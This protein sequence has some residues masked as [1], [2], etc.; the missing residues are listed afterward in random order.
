MRLAI[1]ILLATLVVTQCLHGSDEIPGWPVYNEGRVFQGGLDYVVVHG[2]VASYCMRANSNWTVQL[3]GVVAQHIKA[4]N[5]RGKRIRL[6]AY[7]KTAGA[8]DVGRRDD[9]ADKILSGNSDWVQHTLLLD[10]PADC[11]SID[12]GFV[13]LKGTVWMDDVALDVV[14]REIPVTPHNRNGSPRTDAEYEQST[15]ILKTA[16]RNTGA[17]GLNIVR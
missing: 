8:V 17:A 1:F 4:D 9:R 14:S 13:I 5:Y 6:S 3:A 16:R 7:L 2:G 12:F 10:V 11:V 15:L